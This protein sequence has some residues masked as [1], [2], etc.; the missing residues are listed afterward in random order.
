[1]G[2]TL[3]FVALAVNVARILGCD[4]NLLNDGSGGFT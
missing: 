2:G 3:D 4:F 1:M